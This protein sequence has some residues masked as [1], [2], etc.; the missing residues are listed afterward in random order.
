MTHL[1]DVKVNNRRVYAAPLV[2]ISAVDSIQGK[3]LEIVKKQFGYYVDFPQIWRLP[4]YATTL[5]DK[6]FRYFLI[7]ASIKT[8][9]QRASTSLSVLSLADIL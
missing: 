8:G 7:S 5:S 6:K 9:A 1:E 3:Y 2:Q 4:R